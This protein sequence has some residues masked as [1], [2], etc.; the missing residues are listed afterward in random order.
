MLG[1]SGGAA[2]PTG[3]KGGGGVTA[4][5]APKIPPVHV[6]CASAVTWGVASTVAMRICSMPL[7][8]P[9]VQPVAVLL[10]LST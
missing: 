10:S 7:N 6:C 3:Q 9:L 5:G 4:V 8:D 2:V 1:P